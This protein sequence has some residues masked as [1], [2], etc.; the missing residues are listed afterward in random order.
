M[1]PEISRVN[2]VI[3]LTWALLLIVVGIVGF[4]HALRLI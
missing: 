3:L 1:M 2:K 4:L